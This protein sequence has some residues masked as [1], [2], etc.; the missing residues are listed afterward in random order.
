MIKIFET[1]NLFPELD[2]LSFPSCMETNTTGNMRFS[3]EVPKEWE[4]IAQSVEKILIDFYQTC[5]DPFMNKVE[6]FD[7]FTAF[8]DV[9]S[10]YWMRPH[11]DNR[12]F[13][14]S[15]MLY[16]F[17]DNPETGSLLFYDAPNQRDLPHIMESDY[18]LFKQVQQ[19]KGKLVCWLNS[20]NAYHAPSSVKG[21]RRSIYFAL[22]NSE[23]WV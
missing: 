15:S 18:P 8:M 2:K 3:C 14:V 10:D 13:V 16:V 20:F 12:D 19:S 1:E 17:A 7:L 11:T 6:N 23:A 4:P 22:K 21:K 9:G 5:N